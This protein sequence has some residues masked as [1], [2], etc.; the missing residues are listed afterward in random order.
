MW[1]CARAL[2]KAEEDRICPLAQGLTSKDPSER[3]GLLRQLLAAQCG[4][5][6]MHESVHV[7]NRMICTRPW[8]EWANAMAVVFIENALGMRC[9][10]AAEAHRR[11]AVLA[12]EGAAADASAAGPDAALFYER[13]EATV[14]FS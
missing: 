12:R 3:V 4:D 1:L 8:F 11:A 6:M 13:L 10:D 14:Q 9:D 5:G 7:V 2:A